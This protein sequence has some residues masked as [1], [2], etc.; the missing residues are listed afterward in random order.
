MEIK[1]YTPFYDELSRA[2][3]EKLAQRN[4]GKNVVLSPLSI[5]MLLGICAASS[6]GDTRA[7]ILWTLGREQLTFPGLQ[8]LMA[9]LRDD[10]T[11]NGT[12]LLANAVFIREDLRGTVP[13]RYEAMLE[14]VYG[15]SL[16]AGH[17]MVREINDWVRE[18]TLGMIDGVADESMCQMT[19]G[20]LNAAA[21]EDAWKKPY[22]EGQIRK[23]D[24]TNADGSVSRPE[25]LHSE[26]QRYIEDRF[27][28][29]FVRPYQGGDY[30][31]MALLPTEE[32][33][34]DPQRAL[35]FL[36]FTDRF[37]RAQD[38][39][40]QVAMPEFSCAFGADLTPLCREM[41]IRTAFGRGADFS[42]LSGVPMTIDSV[43]HEA[44]IQVN[45]KGTKA[46]AVTFAGL[47][48]MSAMVSRPKV[49]R[50]DRPFFY[51]VV[52][53]DTALP[54][55]CGAVNHL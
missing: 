35:R 20:L 12:L 27:F 21:F 24:F 15:G 18:N 25:M 7:E 11:E 9:Q 3:L 29:G 45:R 50:L 10:L 16:F 5:L 26:E 28:T 44:R 6:G 37:R 2:L 38:Q 33:R 47:R 34:E 46:A 40:V 42:P 8:D 48:Q 52:H 22:E 17:D 23:E 31:F 32:A 54:V 1:D 41:G 4:A 49:V 55:F 53:N 36:S 43:V 30:S 39:E 14:S 51:A 13:A 19:A